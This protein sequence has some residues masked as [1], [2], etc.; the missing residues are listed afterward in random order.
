MIIIILK[1]KQC[2]CM[3]LLGTVM[4][5]P[6]WH[7]KASKY[8]LVDVHVPHQ[9]L[10][11]KNDTVGI[12]LMIMA[13][14]SNQPAVLHSHCIHRI[15]HCTS[16]TQ[17][18]KYIYTCIQQRRKSYNTLTTTRTEMLSSNLDSLKVQQFST[19]RRGRK[20]IHSTQVWSQ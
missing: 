10:V 9:M 19:V 20:R 1:Y 15:M 13:L 18:Y 5:E 4:T 16:T 7:L 3:E 14:I 6:T 12:Y 8:S 2:T 11:V 17:C